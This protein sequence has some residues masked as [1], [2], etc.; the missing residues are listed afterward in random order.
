[1]SMCEAEV[2][3]TLK[4]LYGYEL[5][6]LALSLLTAVVV[7]LPLLLGGVALALAVDMLRDEHVGGVF[8]ANLG[9][10]LATEGANG[11][12]IVL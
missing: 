9:D 11:D 1:M 4:T 8:A 5:L 7:D 2:F 12:L 3:P 10:D 6:L